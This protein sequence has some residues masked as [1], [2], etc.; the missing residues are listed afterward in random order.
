MTGA[1]PA[2]DEEAMG[3]DTTQFVSVPLDI[4][5][6]YFARAKKVSTQL[7]TSKRLAWLQAKDTEDRSEWLASSESRFGVWGWW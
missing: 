1:L 2:K 5:M 3:A 6:K 4:L 7:P